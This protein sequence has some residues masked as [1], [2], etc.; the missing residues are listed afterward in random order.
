MQFW[1]KPEDM[2]NILAE[3][4]AGRPT[5]I[6]HE[7]GS[8]LDW[9]GNILVIRLT[10]TGKVCNLGEADIPD[11]LEIFSRYLSLLMLLTTPKLTPLVA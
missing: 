1:Q 11:V 7:E 2:H 9:Y 5:S 10:A 6:T 3:R 4:L 8:D